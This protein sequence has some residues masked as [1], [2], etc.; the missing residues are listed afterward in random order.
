MITSI[1]LKSQRRLAV[2]ALALP[3]LCPLGSAAQAIAETVQAPDAMAG[4]SVLAAASLS[5]SSVS[6]A[7]LHSMFMST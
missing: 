5:V 6:T 4:G 7:W 1:L 3:L 2:M